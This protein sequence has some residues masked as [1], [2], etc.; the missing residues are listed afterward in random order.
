MKIIQEREDKLRE[1]TDLDDYLVHISKT[2]SDHKFL[3]GATQGIYKRQVSLLGSIIRAKK[4]VLESVQVLDWGTGKGHISYLLEKEGFQVTS[5]DVN[6]NTI[7]STFGQI[8]P[9]IEEHDINVIPL[10]H[11]WELPFQDNTFDVVV[12]FGVLEHVSHDQASLFEIR[13]VLRTGGIFFFSFLP[14]HYSWT[15]RIAHLR[16]NYYHDRLYSEQGVRCLASNAHFRVEDMWHGQLFP[17]NSLSHSN[18]FERLDRT[19]CKH[20]PL[21]YFATNLEGILIA[22]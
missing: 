9:I 12:S 13:R 3:G 19:L 17:K 4:N 8:T 11:S 16:G 21:R 20:T 15:Q 5:C 6:Q 7:D 1:P 22:E 18:F 14:Y 2:Y 10:E